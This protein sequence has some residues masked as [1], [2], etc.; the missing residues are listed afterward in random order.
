MSL[1]TNRQTLPECKERSGSF[2]T[3]DNRSDE[4]NELIRLHK[5]NNREKL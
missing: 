3:T 5:Q 4:E 2:K 1:K